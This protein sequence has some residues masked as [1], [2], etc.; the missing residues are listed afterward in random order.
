MMSAR[1]L[2][3]ELKAAG[4]SVQADGLQLRVRPAGRLTVQ[5]LAALKQA[6]WDVLDLLAGGDIEHE[7]FEERAAIM[8]FD[9]GL[10]RGQAEAAARA[11]ILRLVHSSKGVRS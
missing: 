2:L 9:G 7:A 6:K 1:V 10:T 5:H 11:L 4:V 8:E 3:E